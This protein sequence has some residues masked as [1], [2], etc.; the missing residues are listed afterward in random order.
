MIPR[1]ATAG[2][3][4][5]AQA[6]IGAG[7]SLAQPHIIP[8]PILPG[9]TYTRVIPRAVSA[10]GSIIVG[11]NDSRSSAVPAI[12]FMW[13]NQ[14]GP[15][16]IPGL[17]EL[18]PQTIARGVSSVGPTIV[19]DL[20]RADYTGAGFRWSPS[21]G[22]QLLAGPTGSTV[23]TYACAITPDGAAIIGSCDRHC[24]RWRA[25][26]PQE[27]P[28]PPGSASGLGIAV[29]PDGSIVVGDLSIGGGTW[30]ATLWQ[31]GSDP[32]QLGAFSSWPETNA[33]AIT[34]S[35]DAIVGEAINSSG[36]S[37]AFRWTSS[38][39]MEFIGFVRPTD[40][41]A[42]LTGITADGRAAVGYSA[43]NF[44]L[45]SHRAAIWREGR[46]FQYLSDVLVSEYGVDLGTWTLHF[47]YAITPDGSVIIG[48]GSRDGTTIEGWLIRLD[49]YPNCDGSTA[50]PVLNVND[51]ICFLNRFAAGDTYANCDASTTPPVLTV[52]DFVCF[53]NRF[54]SGCP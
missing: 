23:G 36:W 39:G 46:G 48:N 16:P 32:Q 52:N 33:N 38:L 28:Q 2:L 18:W 25:T 9:S 8:I 26:G 20:T 14:T 50:P 31:P 27:L 53:L 21:T 34:S 54:V 7:V 37:A 44:G 35:G 5:A 41:D 22:A 4:A 49:C 29:T 11:S 13:Q 30:L 17:S 47:A 40:V 51:F 12:A 6:F 42:S 43:P 19:G 3:G 1:R 10:D 45:E 15:I 24:T